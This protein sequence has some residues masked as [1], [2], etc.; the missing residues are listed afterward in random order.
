MRSERWSPL[1]GLWRL[2]TMLHGVAIGLS[3]LLMPLALHGSDLVVATWNMKWF[4]SGRVDLREEANVEASR[5]AAAGRVLGN[6]WREQSR[7]AR[8]GLVVCTQEMRDAEACTNLVAATEID[9]LKVVA[10]SNFKDNGGVPYWQQTAILSTLPVLDAGYAVWSRADGV[11]I[12]RGFTWALL[13]DGEGPLAC[14]CL[15]LKS[16]VNKS[17][18]E[19]E[20]QKNIY[21]RE[22]AAGQVLAMVRVF[23]RKFA[24]LPLR[25]VV[26]G[27]FN[28]TE[29]D[30][31]YVSEATLRSFYGAH[32]RSCFRDLPRERR[33]THP[34]NGPHPDATFDYILYR[35]FERIVS[36]RIYDG[37]CISDHNT[38]FLRLR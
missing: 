27:D 34:A 5:I 3:L 35:G 13:D 17:G 19:I 23:Q 11:M 30:L 33:V 28:T 2:K 38:V 6:A 21:K 20:D 12:P 25:V 15:H 1:Q 18:T 16:N 4:P 14:F 22:S 37:T 36:R 7:G 24:D 32:F 8:P 10:V 26:A 9:G 29:D 31:V